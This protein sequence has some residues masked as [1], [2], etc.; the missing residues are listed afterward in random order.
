M[1]W[2]DQNGLFS[3]RFFSQNVISIA[4]SKDKGHFIDSFINYRRLECVY[5]NRTA[6]GLINY[7]LELVKKFWSLWPII[8]RRWV[9]TLKGATNGNQQPLSVVCKGK[10]EKMWHWVYHESLETPF[11]IHLFLKT[12]LSF[13]ISKSFDW[14]FSCCF[15]RRK[16]WTEFWVIVAKSPPTPFCVFHGGKHS[17]L[18]RQP[19][20]VRERGF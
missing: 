17:A 10:H 14:W 5:G 7:Y 6:D 1:H 11:S 9:G 15:A 18:Q 12:L 19:F 20:S 13:F 8:Y 3:F 2:W 4:K 16:D